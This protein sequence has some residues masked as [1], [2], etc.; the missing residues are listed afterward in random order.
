M[1]IATEIVLTYNPEG[2][3]FLMRYVIPS[4]L[5]STVFCHSFYNSEGVE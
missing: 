3:S 1:I 5:L 4:G 2:V